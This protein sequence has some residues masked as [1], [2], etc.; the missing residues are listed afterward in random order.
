MNIISLK[1]KNK[2]IKKCL[3]K[4]TT[5]C[6]KNIKNK[7]SKPITDKN[8]RLITGDKINYNLFISRDVDSYI[9][10]LYFLEKYDI[11]IIHSKKTI[12]KSSKPEIDKILIFYKEIIDKYTNLNGLSIFWHDKDNYIFP[13]NLV[14][15]IKK[16]KKN[17]IF[18]FVT[19]IN[20][21]MD[22]ANCL[23][24]D[25]NN[26]RIIHFEPYGRTAKLSLKEFDDTCKDMFKS[27]K[28]EYYSPE[29]YLKTNSYQML[30]NESNPLEEKT[31][32]IGGFCL[33][34]TLW[35]FELYLRN[36]KYEPSK[37]VEKSI[38]EI[39]NSKY[40]VMEYIRFYANKLR[41]YHIKY[42]KKIKYPDQKIFNVNTTHAEKDYIYQSINKSIGDFI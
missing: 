21:K 34:W 40:S 33:A 2:E 38:N 22:H 10:L 16:S 39:I 17:I 23:I 27:L 19:I 18:I 15:A 26:K 8:L 25:K 24:I 35:F 31:G 13:T 20:V 28:Y 4:Q 5:K 37:L 42:L 9:Y 7:M 12:I 30:S 41:K 1:N 14:K 29:D 3:S 36:T 6:I 32:D 11:G